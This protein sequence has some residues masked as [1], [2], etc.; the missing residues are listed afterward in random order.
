MENRVVL[1]KLFQGGINTDVD[2]ADLSPEQAE[3]LR[4]VMWNQNGDLEK[5]GAFLY[6]SA[7]NPLNSRTQ[8]MTGAILL[9]DRD[10][11]PPTYK[12][13]AGDY[14]GHVGPLTTYSYTPG[15]ANTSGAATGT[16]NVLNGGSF[17]YPFP[18]VVYQ[19]EVIFLPV[20][21]DGVTSAGTPSC[22]IRYAGS[23]ATENTSPAGTVSI[24]NGQ[25]VV[26]GIGTSFL[27][28]IA[29]GQ[30]LW[31]TDPTWGIKTSYLVAQVETDTRLRLAL[32][33][34]QVTIAGGAYQAL[35]Y[36]LVG[37]SS[38]V[39]E[40]GLFTVAGA[41]TA[42]TGRATTWNSLLDRVAAG[43][44][45]LTDSGY[46]EKNLI[47]AVGSNLALTL[48]NGFALP[49]TGA[50]YRIGRPLAG[51][52]IAAHQN[53]LWVAGLPW[54]P[55]RLQVTPA[56]MNLSDTYNGVDS[57]TQPGA[58]SIVDSVEIPSPY[59]P[60]S[61][62]ALETSNEPGPLLVLRDRDA[63]VVYGEWPS[64]QVTKLGD[65]I[66]CVHQLASCS[67]ELGFFWAGMTGVFHY[68][69][70]GGVKDLTQ[71][72]LTNDWRSFIKTVT[73]NAVY[74]VSVDVVVGY[75]VISAAYGSSS[76]P[77]TFP[78]TQ[79]VYDIRRQAW[80]TWTGPN[81][82]SL[83]PMQYGGYPKELVGTDYSTNRLIT[84]SGALDPTLA[85]QANGVNGTLLARSGRNL[86]GQAGEKGRVIDGKLTY[87][88]TGSSPQL[89]VKFGSATLDTA[90]TITTTTTGSAY[91]TTRMYPSSGSLGNEFRDVQVEFS[92]TSGTPT[93]LELNE[94]SWVTR[95]RRVRA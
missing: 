64:V 92:E 62:V 6:A 16:R 91:N 95:K 57:T 28:K 67:S 71:G 39:T 40:R 45:W 48:S 52:V 63:Y 70:G 7:A 32:A 9:Q 14:G 58:A 4:D 47:S 1:R 41:G 55:N 34:S 90:A 93:R 43:Y 3:S 76:P 61:I 24:S 53:R 83:T 69:P 42:V 18:G 66:G 29:A 77:S 10:T 13:I 19:G 49:N 8:K 38:L 59:A 75:L 25:D 37:L 30:Y 20:G 73:Q 15:T 84:I 89:T 80:T 12:L 44:D 46:T 88:M 17:G 56:G 51:R 27:T 72:A 74:N 87:R 79:Y 78:S 26:V 33:P 35:N 86:L 82:L 31:V 5:R 60:G 23:T 2:T 11:S 21:Q 22:L 54:A 68:Q 81:V 50:P 85:G 94:F 36:G 65:N